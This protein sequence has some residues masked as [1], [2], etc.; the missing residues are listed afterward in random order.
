VSPRPNTHSEI[1]TLQAALAGVHAAL[2]GYGVL[3][4][5]LSGEEEERGRRAYVRYR[6][7]RDH[8]V[9]LLSERSVEPVAAA[10][11]YTLPFPVSDAAS[12]RRLAA[13]LEAGCAGVFADLVAGATSAKLRG[14]AAS[15]LRECALRHLAWGGAL[16]AFPGLPRPPARTATTPTPDA[17]AR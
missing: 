8:L 12:A 4:P 14:F 1:E 15:T 17:P 7:L 6:E 13:H 3:G 5:R 16:S 11:G 9:A 10:A 2:W